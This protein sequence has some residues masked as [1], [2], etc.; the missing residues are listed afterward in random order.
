MQQT[1][2]VFR[3]K[4]RI[5][6]T[7]GKELIANPNIALLELIK[8]SYDADAKSVNI[9][10]YMEGT[11]RHIVIS[12]DGHGMTKDDI[13]NKWLVL[14]TANKKQKTISPE[15]RI[16]LGNKGIG[17]YASALLGNQLKITSYTQDEI[18]TLELDWNQFTEDKFLDE[19]NISITTQPNNQNPT[20]T[21]IEIINTTSDNLF[22]DINEEKLERDLSVLI[23]TEHEFCIS[24]QDVIMQSYQEK[25]PEVIKELYHFR[26]QGTIKDDGT[27][28]AT[29]TIKQDDIIMETKEFNSSDFVAVSE[30]GRASC[31]ERV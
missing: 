22:S 9:N 21:T 2:N 8:N 14:A 26:M 30:I 16:L 25:Y 10:N 5:I 18:V 1:Q 13:E 3:P 31:R 29:F 7:I 24:Y 12:D 28:Q 19:I 23:D 4:A 27:I 15:G 20:G 6:H 17:R 11:I